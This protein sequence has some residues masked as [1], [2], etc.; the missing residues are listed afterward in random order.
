MT[1]LMLFYRKY[2]Q[3]AHNTLRTLSAS[4]STTLSPILGAVYLHRCMSRV[5]SEITPLQ[6]SMNRRFHSGIHRPLVR[7]SILFSLTGGNKPCFVSRVQ[8]PG[9]CIDR[10]QL[11]GKPKGAKSAT[12]GMY[13]RDA[14]ITFVRA[15]PD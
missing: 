14:I 3:L 9:S 15:G 2:H 7:S 13:L 11:P 1:L 10:R 5:I 12:S 6:E 8:P 4:R